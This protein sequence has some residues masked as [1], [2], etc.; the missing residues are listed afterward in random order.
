MAKGLSALIWLDSMKCRR[1]G[2]FV[3]ERTEYSTEKNLRIVLDQ[4]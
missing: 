3:V 4:R 2:T 1:Y